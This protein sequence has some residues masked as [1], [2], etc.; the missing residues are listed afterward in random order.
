MA[1]K[2]TTSVAKTTN[3]DVDVVDGNGEKREPV[4]ADGIY[5]EYGVELGNGA[6]V[7]IEVIVDKRK[8]PA[9]YGLLLAEGNGPAIIMATLTTRTRRFLDWAGATLD[10]IEDVLPGVISRGQ[11]FSEDS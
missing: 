3:A 4:F 9:S 5:T 8:L 2:K 10:D 6:E 11:E 1:T 7:D